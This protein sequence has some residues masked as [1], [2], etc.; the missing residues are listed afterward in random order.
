MKLKIFQDDSNDIMQKERDEMAK[1]IEAIREEVKDQII[2]LER[3][4]DNLNQDIKDYKEEIAKLKS[5]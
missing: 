5:S 1:Q 2:S 3:E 4:R